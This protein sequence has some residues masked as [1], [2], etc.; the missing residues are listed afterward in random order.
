MKKSDKYRFI[1]STGFVL[2]EIPV[3]VA[4][5]LT[6]D[7]GR[8]FFSPIFFLPN[9]PLKYHYM[10]C[11]KFK[12]YKKV[13]KNPKCPFHL[14]SPLHFLSLVATAERFFVCLLKKF[15]MLVRTEVCVGISLFQNRILPCIY[16]V[17]HVLV[18]NLKM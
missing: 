4:L 6:C 7:L 17:L 16:S 14:S 1:K 8:V 11:Q 5:P 15:S 10:Q 2:R 12:Q 3:P 18:F 13:Y 9:W